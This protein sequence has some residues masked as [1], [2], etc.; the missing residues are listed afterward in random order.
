MFY[1]IIITQLLLTTQSRK[2]TIL[3][4]N[5]KYELLGRPGSHIAINAINRR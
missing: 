5:I 2:I 4:V 1:I 3:F